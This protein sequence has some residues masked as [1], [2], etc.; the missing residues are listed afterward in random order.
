MK[1]NE[2]KQIKELSVSQLQGKAKVLKNEMADLVLDK[3]MKKIKDLKIVSKKRKELAQI[4]TVVRQKE[5]LGELE[6]RVKSQELSEKSEEPEKKER[7]KK[8]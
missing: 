8:I 5:S 2:F 7:K 6:F 3:N 1:K 4:L